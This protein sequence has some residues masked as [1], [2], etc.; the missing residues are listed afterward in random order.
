MMNDEI[1]NNNAEM[2]NEE[3]DLLLLAFK[4]ACETIMNDS[5]NEAS[6]RL[7]RACFGAQTEEKSIARYLMTGFYMGVH[8]GMRIVAAING[9]SEYLAQCDH[10]DD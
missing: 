4:H 2:T 6:I 5:T 9:D 1:M 8:E 3:D 7:A 10:L